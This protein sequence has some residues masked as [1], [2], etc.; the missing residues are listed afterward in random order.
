M[1][2]DEYRALTNIDS[3]D[4]ARKLLTRTNRLFAVT[5]VAIM[6]AYITNFTFRP[7][8]ADIQL[9][10]A[11]ALLYGVAI[12]YL[13]YHCWRLIKRL[14]PVTNAWAG[15][16]IIFAPIAPISWI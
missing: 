15:W 2:R 4:A 11:F 8:T 9:F 1:T 13:T 12:L 14:G 3:Q 7:D 16:V 10:G 5:F 6:P